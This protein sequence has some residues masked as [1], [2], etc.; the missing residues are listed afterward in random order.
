MRFETEDEEEGAQFAHFVHRDE[1]VRG[2]WCCCFR[3]LV[4]LFEKHEGS[5]RNESGRLGADGSTW[6]IRKR[7]WMGSSGSSL[8]LGICTFQ[9]GYEDD[10]WPELSPVCANTRMC[11][12]APHTQHSEKERASD[13][14][15]LRSGM[16][17]GPPRR[18][19][20]TSRHEA[21]LGT[22]QACF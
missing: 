21:V 20:V 8:S 22:G 11:R 2:D 7:E 4:C 1:I 5:S 6:N 3:L 17:P 15:S 10:A 13:P 16:N 19:D 14:Q 9:V 12:S 18:A